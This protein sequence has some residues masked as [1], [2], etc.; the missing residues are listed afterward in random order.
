M[1]QKVTETQGWE[2]TV[3]HPKAEWLEEKG[4]KDWGDVSDLAEGRRRVPG[5]LP[6]PSRT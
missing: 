5:P 1:V 6:D 4:E 2:M 3:P